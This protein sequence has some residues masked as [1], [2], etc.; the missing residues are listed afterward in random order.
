MSLLSN[1]DGKN[2]AD[3]VADELRTAIQRGHYAPGTRLVERRLASELG[4]SHVPIRE[5]LAR[6][7]DEG[8]VERL[9]RRGSRVAGLSSKQ[10]EELSS[11]R[12]LLEGFV[13]TRVQERLTPQAEASVRKIVSSMSEAAQ[14]GDVHRVFDLDQRFHE[15][16]WHLADHEMLFE[17][18]AQLRGR[19]DAFLLATTSALDTSEL[20]QHAASHAEVVDA[21]ASGDP[22][23][24]PRR[25][26]P[27]HRAGPGADS[28]VPHSGRTGADLTRAEQA[29]VVITD[30]DLPSRGVEEGILTSAGLEV[31]REACRTGAD[32]V[33]AGRD[34]EALIS[35][36]APITAEVLAQLPRCRIVSRIG[37]GLDMIDIEAAT[38]LGIAVANTPDYCIEEVSTHAIALILACV[39]GVLTLDQAVRAGDW[40]GTSAVPDAEASVAYHDCRDGVRTDRLQDSDRRCG[41]WLS[42]HRSRPVRDR[43]DHHCQRS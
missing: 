15:R 6:L 29:V 37:I 23:N 19:I 24:C 3:K 18:V 35:Q 25:H 8:L 22:R 31:R 12:I 11:L 21:I 14:L 9:P 16:L 41:S 38:R 43:R 13:A 17:S 34:A 33:A 40:N 7:A 36:W 42:C 5:A 10:L 1:L 32:V 26:D 27:S 20:E 30:S 28:T 39:R 4:V 2:L